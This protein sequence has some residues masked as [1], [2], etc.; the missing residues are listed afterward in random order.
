MG[1]IKNDSLKEIKWD[2]FI[3]FGKNI[4]NSF[5][6]WVA[7]KREFLYYDRANGTGKPSIY[8]RDWEKPE[9]KPGDIF[10]LSFNFLLNELTIYDGEIKA[11]T[12]SLGESKQITPAFSMHDSNEEIEIIKYEIKYS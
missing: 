7:S 2:Q 4:D 3:G 5:G 10:I 8:R 6:I 12:I 11:D 9:F 1:F